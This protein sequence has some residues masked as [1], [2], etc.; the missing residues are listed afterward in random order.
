[1]EISKSMNSLPC[2]EPLCRAGQ[3]LRET[4]ERITG[5]FLQLKW[6]LG[7]DSVWG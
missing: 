4:I 3:A 1:M 5:D 7:E 2:T 6:D